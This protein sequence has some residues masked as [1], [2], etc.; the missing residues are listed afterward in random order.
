M[1]LSRLGKTRVYVALL[2]LASVLCGLVFTGLSTVYV[3]LAV[4][5]EGWSERVEIAKVSA[6]VAFLTATIDR[7]DNIHVVFTDKRGDREAVFYLRLGTGGRLQIP[8][9]QVSEGWATS[10]SPCVAVDYDGNAHI[11]WVD[12]RD[13]N[14]EI[15][16]VRVDASGTKTVFDKRLTF[17]PRQ[18]LAPAV[19]VDS[20]GNVHIVWQDLREE[21]RIFPVNFEVYYLK[22]DN[23]GHVLVSERRLTPADTSYSLGPSIAIDSEDRVHVFWIDNRETEP[24]PSHELYYRRLDLNGNALTEDK[25]ITPISKRVTPPRAPCPIIDTDGNVVF[26]FLDERPRLRYGIYLK[27]LDSNGTSLG[28]DRRVMSSSRVLGGYAGRPAATTGSNGEVYVIS[29]DLRPDWG[30]QKLYK[31]ECFRLLFGSWQFTPLYLEFRRELYGV[32]LDAEQVLNEDWITS[33]L[34]S[35]TMPSIFTDSHGTTH[36]I[37]LQTREKLSTIT[38]VNDAK[39]TR[40]VIVSIV[41]SFRQRILY[42]WQVALAVFALF[43]MQEFL[44]LALLLI[45]A[46]LVVVCLGRA[47]DSRTKSETKMVIIQLLVL[48]LVK[49]ALLNLLSVSMTYPGGISQFLTGLPAVM[50]TVGVATRGGIQMGTKSKQILVAFVCELLNLFY[51]LCLIAPMALEPVY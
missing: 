25:K 8:V 11:V 44:Y 17:D 3:R 42:N 37:W 24:S 38:Y 1:H 34:E 51:T 47:L 48:V 15:Y 26:A 35:S 36:L 31:E 12:N 19:A 27:R 16:Y 14:D 7:S 18:S 10:T 30:T 6:N 2:L 22:L 5:P 13:G 39:P 32:R 41:A 49:A 20:K 4:S 46:G 21:V 28:T 23:G 29:S 45:A 33:T 50:M 43:A 40:P 9:L